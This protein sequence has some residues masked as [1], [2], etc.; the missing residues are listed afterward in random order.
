[1]TH[2]AAR[3]RSFLLLAAVIAVGHPRRAGAQQT[4]GSLAVE[5]G[6]GWV[7]WW[8]ADSAPIRWDSADARVAD[9]VAWHAG[10]PGIRWGTLRLSGPGEAW[11][12][13]AIL[14]QFDPR[15]VRLDLADGLNPDLTK[16][17][18]IDS[19][20]PGADFAFNAGQFEYAGPWG[21]VVRDSAEYGIPGGG[22]LAATIVQDTAGALRFIVAADSVVAARRRRVRLAFQSFPLVLWHDGE[23]HPF[24]RTAGH[25]I[26]L[27]HRDARLG[28][29]AL[30]DGTWLVVL[31]RFEG[32]GGA[33]DVLPF[34]LTTPEMTALLGALG[35]REAVLLDGGVSG[36]L[37]VRDSAGVAHYWRG[38]RKVP[39]GM[40]G[41]GGE[42]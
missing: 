40:V 32:F 42:Q 27:L 41:R 9:A 37:L 31:T 17:W 24:I 34:G 33:L 5:T 11:R 19:A 3:S 15:H 21:W 38:L 35:C 29:C 12:V 8:R 16:R 13:A 23:V 7:S 25:P 1:M 39:L 6:V 18:T 14:V 2:G 20:P 10:R 4:S 26:D 36:Q 22:P 28:L 30:R